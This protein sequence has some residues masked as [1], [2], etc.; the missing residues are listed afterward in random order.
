MIPPLR[1]LQFFR[2]SLFWHLL[3]LFRIDRIRMQRVSIL[4]LLYHLCDKLQN[5]I[6]VWPL[7]GHQLAGDEYVVYVYLEGANP[8][9]NDLFTSVPIHK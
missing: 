3:L 9:K 5:L 4:L 1:T 2:N 8:R 7:I 6:V